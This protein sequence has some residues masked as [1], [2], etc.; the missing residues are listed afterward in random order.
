MR[1]PRASATTTL[2]ARQPGRRLLLDQ[3][4]SARASAPRALPGYDLLLQAMSGLMSVTGEPDGRPLKVGAALIDMICGLLRH[5]S[6]SWP[7]CARASATAAGQ[8]VEVSLMDSRAGR[9]AQPGLGVPQRRARCPGAWATATRRSPPTRRSRP[10][11]AT[12][13]SRSA[14]TRSSRRLCDVVGPPELAGDERFATNAARMEH[15]DELA[16][17]L[18]AALRR[19]APAADW[20]ARAGRGGRA[21]RADQRRRAGLRASPRRSGLEPVDETDG[22]PHG[23]LAAAPRR[24]R[25]RRCAAGRRAWASTT[26]RSAP[27]SR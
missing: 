10:P 19:R 20:V 22:V 6:A 4:A 17:E 26:R 9:P 2:R 24:A 14:T 11:T 27:G 1:P 23:A 3:R 25:R 18:E 12:S 7:R 16:A 8:H 21:G 15:R 5:R 13:R